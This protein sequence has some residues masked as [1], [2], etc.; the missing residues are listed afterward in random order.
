VGGDGSDVVA[1]DKN[2][3]VDLLI[4]LFSLPIHLP[5]RLAERSCFRRGVDAEVGIHNGEVANG[6]PNKRH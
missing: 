4:S 5:T 3:S 1:L 6:H 2:F